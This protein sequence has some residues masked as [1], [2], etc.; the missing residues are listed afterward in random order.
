ML[1]CFVL[2]QKTC[3][4]KFVLK[5]AH[6][7]KYKLQQLFEMLSLSLNT[8][9]ESFSPLVIGPVNNG[10]LKVSPDLHQSLLQFS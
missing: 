1:Y 5:Q 8:G 3:F 7:S 10:L 9:L 4:K 2:K 6:I